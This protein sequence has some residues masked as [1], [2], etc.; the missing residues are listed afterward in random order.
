M[1]SQT[2]AAARRAQTSPTDGAAPPVRGAP[3][4]LHWGCGPKAAPGWIN[5][6]A[7]DLP[8]VDVVGDIRRGLPIPSES[9]RYA[10]SIHALQDLP[11]LDVAP[12][13][14]ELHRVLEPGG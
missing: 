11:F 3:R 5:S 10:S 2:D 1:A 9:V 12:A 14:R 8:G 6:D 4:R 13:L 7:L